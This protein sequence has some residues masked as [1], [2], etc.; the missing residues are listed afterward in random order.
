MDDGRASSVVFRGGG[1][2]TTEDIT[3]SA[4]IMSG[5]T[6]LARGSVEPGSIKTY[7]KCSNKFTA[8]VKETC[9][10]LGRPPWPHCTIEELRDLVSSKGVV[11]GF[12]AYCHQTGLRSETIDVYI[13][14]L[15]FWGTDGFG[16]P[17]LSDKIAVQRLLQGCKKAQGPPKDGKLGIGIIRLR[18]LVAHLGSQVG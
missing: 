12:I 10:G 18:K 16:R 7:A 3:H 2:S 9:V 15:K 14:A 11:E 13:S 1:S 4:V 5:V 8:F 17:I 6:K